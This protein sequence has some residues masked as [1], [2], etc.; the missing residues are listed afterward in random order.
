MNEM[1][2]N[3]PLHAR[4]D[5]SA[6]EPNKKQEEE[7]AGS[8]RRL[9]FYPHEDDKQKLSS[10]L[11]KLFQI[12]KVESFE[13]QALIPRASGRALGQAASAAAARAARCR[14]SPSELSGM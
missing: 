10:I 5:P 2:L 12:A 4:F 3:F 6:R 13:S 7:A 8:R 9:L 14:E 1:E 11:S